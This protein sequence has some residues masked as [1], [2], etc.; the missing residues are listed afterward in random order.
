MRPREL[1]V[2]TAWPSE[3]P[4]RAS[5]GSTDWGTQLTY[6][7]PATTSRLNTKDDQKRIFM[8][9]HSREGYTVWGHC[10]GPW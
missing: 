7:Q 3:L 5:K 6:M 2:I 1:G 4:G 10:S 9:H 8:E